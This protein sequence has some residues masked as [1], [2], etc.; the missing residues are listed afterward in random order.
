MLVSDVLHAKGSE[1][2]TIDPEATV[3]EAIAKMVQKNI[4]SLPVVDHDG[5]LIGLFAERDVLRTF[6]NRGDNCGRLPLSDVMT[7][8]PLTCRSDADVNDI[9]GQMTEKRAPKIPVVDGDK[10]VGIISVGDIVK[11]MYEKVS[12]ENRHL[13]SY[14]HGAV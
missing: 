8:K 2:F 6:H 14:I 9:M 5:R 4:G 12:T 13:I 1:L 3:Q 11:V 7:R 10:L